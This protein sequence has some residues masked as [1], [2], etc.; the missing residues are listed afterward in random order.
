MQG[1]DGFF[2]HHTPLHNRKIHD[3]SVLVKT[4]TTVHDPSMRPAQTRQNRPSQGNKE[5]RA[6]QRPTRFQSC[7][8]A[9]I[10]Y[11]PRRNRT[12]N[13]VIKSHLLCQLS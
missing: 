4:S 9:L 13:L 6:S 12:D 2:F 11:A 5:K 10:S 3:N 1:M 8:S 7:C